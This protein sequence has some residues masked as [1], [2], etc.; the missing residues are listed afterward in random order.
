MTPPETLIERC[1]PWPVDPEE[2]IV[3]LPVATSW[4]SNASHLLLPLTNPWATMASM[5]S[6]AA[7]WMEGSRPWIR[8]LRQWKAWLCAEPG[9]NSLSLPSDQG[10]AW[11]GN[12]GGTSLV[13]LEEVLNSSF[14]LLFSYLV[15]LTK[16]IQELPNETLLRKWY[17]ARSCCNAQQ[18]LI[19][20]SLR[21]KWGQFDIWNGGKVL[22]N[23]MIFEPLWIETTRRVIDGLNVYL[24]RL[25]F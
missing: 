3:L 14:G 12:I 1:A 7:R 2:C 17:S 18:S 20:F 8:Q 15:Q 24:V 10:R 13:A 21:R 23:L 16:A 22:M 9:K 4:S 19:N 11:C 25:W 6:P 5:A